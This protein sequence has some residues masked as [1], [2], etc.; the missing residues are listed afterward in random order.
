[1]AVRLLLYQNGGAAYLRNLLPS[2]LVLRRCR[3]E[4]LLSFLSPRPLSFLSAWPLAVFSAKV[5][6]GVSARLLA[7]KVVALGI[8]HTTGAF[9]VPV[10]LCVCLAA[11][12][13]VALAALFLVAVVA[14]LLL[15]AAVVVMRVPAPLLSI[16]AVVLLKRQKRPLAVGVPVASLICVAASSKW[17]RA[18]LLPLPP[19]VLSLLP[20]SCLGFLCA[21]FTGCVSFPLSPPCGALRSMSPAASWP[22]EPDPTPPPPHPA[23][24]H[25]FR[26]LRPKRLFVALR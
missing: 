17:P 11:V 22:A 24:P 18:F 13:L 23:P 25:C 20:K 21:C 4:W 19:A 12:F 6:I 8:R 9:I 3:C 14:C 15:V 1:M 26:K 2:L 7:S 5:A 10:V 16:G